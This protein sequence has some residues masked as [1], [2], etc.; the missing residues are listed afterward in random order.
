MRKSDTVN[1]C[2]AAG[3]SYLKF[4][5]F[6]NR[7]PLAHFRLNSKPLPDPAAAA[8]ELYKNY[9]D[10]KKFKGALRLSTCSVVRGSDAFFDGLAGTLGASH[11]KVESGCVSNLKIDYDPPESLGA[12]RLCAAS[13]AWE[14]F[15]AESENLVVIDFGTATTMNLIT[16]GT[17]RGGLILPGFGLYSETLGRSCD[18]LFRVHFNRISGY[19][20][21][22]TESAL[23]AGIYGGYSTMIDGVYEKLL[24]DA[25]LSAGSVCAVTTGGLANFFTTNVGFPVICAPHLVL[26]GVE[27]ISERVPRR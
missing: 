7:K 10:L 17:F 12:D 6:R 9:S 16:K 5:V 18:Y 14:R 11:R 22:D 2:A 26:E 4:C 25:G 19:L 20:C 8:A 1:V 24:N 3:N 23:V 15:S 27:L 13:A 21:R